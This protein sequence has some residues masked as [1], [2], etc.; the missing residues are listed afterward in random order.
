MASF[1][2]YLIGLG[3]PIAGQTIGQA[4]NPMPAVRALG[5]GAQALS[6]LPVLE[7]LFDFRGGEA[8]RQPQT[9][10]SNRRQRL[11]D[12]KR[13][14]DEI[15]QQANT[16]KTDEQLPNEE[17][18]PLP[19]PSPFR[20]GDGQTRGPGGDVR[21]PNVAAPNIDPLSAGMLQMGLALMTPQWGNAFS[22]LGQAGSEGV[23]ASGRAAKTNEAE[24]RRVD[25]EDENDTTAAQKSRLTEA[26]INKTEAEAEYIGSGE[27]SRSKRLRGKNPTVLDVLAESEK[28]GPK[29]KAYLAQR[30]KSLNNE[31]V[32]G[33][34]DADPTVRFQAM[35][36]EAKKL[37]GVE[38]KEAKPPNVGGTETAQG[39]DAKSL[40]L[41][42]SLEEA[43]KLPSGSAFR[44]L[45]NG[46]EMI[47]KVP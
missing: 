25:T 13:S 16:K 40:P 45:R 37:D 47:G 11:E 24:A 21:A 8:K 43:K 7:P 26:Q 6:P 38:T 5:K 29:G 19:E 35:V 36:D 44:I 3:N 30:V 31:D 42:T 15:V 20:G 46:Q 27:S 22:Q 12:V 17:G 14:E 23:A 41:V 34:E 4:A 33:D 32:L 2:D 39:V 10:E 18:V 28:L 9:D 1:L